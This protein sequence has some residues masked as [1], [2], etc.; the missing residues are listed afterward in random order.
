MGGLGKR[1]EDSALRRL[2]AHYPND[3]VVFEAIE[4]CDWQAVN[5]SSSAARESAARQGGELR[6]LL[7]ERPRPAVVAVAV[8]PVTRVEGSGR[9]RG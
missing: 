7:A 9:L 3:E 4:R 8:D 2:A 1:A 5:A 6:R